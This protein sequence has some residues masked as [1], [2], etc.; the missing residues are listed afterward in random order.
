MVDYNPFSLENKKILITGA[1]SGIGRATAIECS[2]LGATLFIIARDETRLNETYISLSGNNHTQIIIDIQ[3]QH[4]VDQLSNQLPQIDG[5]V[6]C[7]G[8]LT[9]LLFQ[10]IKKEDLNH[11]MDINFTS[12]VMLTQS[13]ISKNKISKN[14]SIV[15]ISSIMGTLVSTLA[16]SMYASTKGALEGMMKGMALDLS[17]KNIR[18]NCVRPGMVQSNFISNGAITDEQLIKDAKTNYPLKRYGKPEEIAY[19]TI[20][21]LSD[22]SNWITGTSILIDGGYTLK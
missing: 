22:A 18:V 14:G 11:I 5:V 9:T 6:N 12:P 4:K 17:S 20:F 13:L 10:F 1:S 16:N 3:D 2:K 7:A 8:T 21:L 15:F 19:S